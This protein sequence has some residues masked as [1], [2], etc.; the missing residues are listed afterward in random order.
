MTTA[1]A[2]ERYRRT[3]ARGAL[4]FRW[5]SLAW[6]AVLALSDGDALERPVLAWISIGGAA[7]WTLWLSLSDE[8]P[9]NAVLA[10]DLALCTYLMLLS[11][12]VI[13]QGEVV[14]NRPFFAAAYPVN[15]VLLWAIVRGSVAGVIA[16]AVLGLA[17]VLTRPLNGIGFDELTRTEW[18]NIGGATVLY[19]VGGAAVG[20]VLRVLTDSGTALER[21]TT[22]LLIERE[23]AG[24]LAERE[25]L[26]REI[27]DSVLQALALVHK[28][29]R[30][31]ATHKTVPSGE[32]AR[33]AEIAG[34]QEAELRGMILRQPQDAPS[35][36]VSLREALERE[37]RSVED[38]EVTVSSV[39]AVVLEAHAAGEIAAATRQ[40]LENVTRHAR[41]TR[42]SVFAEEEDGFVVVTVR[43]DGKG[44]EFDEA[45]LRA[46]NKVGM[47]KS[48]KG[49]VVDLGGTMTVDSAP[50]RG[51]EI[52]F[53]VPLTPEQGETR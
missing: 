15:A 6:M 44:F 17:L 16:G 1:S 31:L 32:V 36:R 39:G 22:E 33:L 2:S 24:R 4:V 26:A 52:E 23:R 28:R 49:R 19:L 21:A 29:G 20:L 25:S 51:T 3:L 40:A 38:V 48:M 27:H 43:D 8:R 5:V 34:R 7:A 35:G 30:E 13:T 18:Q 41:A 10:V 45:S 53:R 50:G 42:A 47:L 14:S 37:T 12:L 9:T 11:G 46:S